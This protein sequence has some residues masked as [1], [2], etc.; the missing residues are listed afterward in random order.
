MQMDKNTLA[1]L[2]SL[3]DASL[4]AAIRMLAASAGLSLGEGEFAKSTLDA[5]R[6]A[7]RGATDA[8]IAKAKQIFEGFRNG[9]K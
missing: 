4:S 8:D 1:S 6:T 5:L 3:D 2:A 9:R 7:L